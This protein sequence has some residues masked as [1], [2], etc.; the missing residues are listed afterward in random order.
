[1]LRKPSSPKRK[2]QKYSFFKIYSFCFCDVSEAVV[3]ND[4]LYCNAELSGS[5]CVVVY[6]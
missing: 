4:S 1:L 2:H 6:A 5:F 3:F